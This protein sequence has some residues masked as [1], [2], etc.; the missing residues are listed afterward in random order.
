MLVTITRLKCDRC[1]ATSSEHDDGHV[2]NA[3]EVM[4]LSGSSPRRD[5]CPHCTMAFNAWWEHPSAGEPKEATVD[6]NL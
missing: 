5:L 1:G 4:Q 2:L 3:W 6:D